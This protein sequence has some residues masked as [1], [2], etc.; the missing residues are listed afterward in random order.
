MNRKIALVCFALFVLPA[1]AMPGAA[2]PV[3]DTKVSPGEVMSEI[4]R[5]VRKE[6][7][8]RQGLRCF[9]RR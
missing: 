9:Q 3:L 2:A 7:Y 6:F 1:V 8:D 4:G 5:I